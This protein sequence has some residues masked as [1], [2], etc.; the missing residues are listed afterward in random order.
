MRHH[1]LHCS[2]LY[3]SVHLLHCA[4]L[5]RCHVL[6]I[7][8]KFTVCFRTDTYSQCQSTVLVRSLFICWQSTDEVFWWNL[9]KTLVAILNELLIPEHLTVYLIFMLWI[10]ERLGIGERFAA[11]WVAAL[12]CSQQYVWMCTFLQLWFLVRMPA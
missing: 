1:C 3:S 9:M 7:E 4:C 2:T 8:M 10:C 5:Y 12:V 11:N 6:K